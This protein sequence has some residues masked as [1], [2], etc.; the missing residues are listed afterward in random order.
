M[1]KRGCS[2]WKDGGRVRHGFVLESIG[3]SASGVHSYRGE[4]T[5][6]GRG[7]NELMPVTAIGAHLLYKQ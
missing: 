2:I 3:L 6:L 7:F 1:I 4:G 5:D